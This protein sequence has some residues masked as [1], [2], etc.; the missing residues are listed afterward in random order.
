MLFVTSQL[1][2]KDEILNL[3]LL[4]WKK[5]LG[6]LPS[7]H[8]RSLKI[9]NVQLELVLSTHLSYLEYCF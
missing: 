7:L 9:L 2:R 8:I 3:N 5:S 4:T 1:Q 6:N